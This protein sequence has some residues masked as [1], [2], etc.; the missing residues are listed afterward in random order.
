[1]GSRRVSVRHYVDV[2]EI[3]N[4]ELGQSRIK[5]WWFSRLESKKEPRHAGAVTFILYTFPVWDC[6]RSKDFYAQ[7]GGISL[8]IREGWGEGYQRW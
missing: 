3:L 5:G 2:A 8:D 4:R 7:V 1:M 6:W